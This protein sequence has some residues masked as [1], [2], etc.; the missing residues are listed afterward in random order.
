M[1]YTPQTCRTMFTSQQAGRML[2]WLN[3]VLVGWIIGI[4]VDADQT[5]GPAPLPV[6]F[7][8]ATA[9]TA[10]SWSWDFGDGGTS[11]EANPFHLFE[12]PGKRDVTIT[13]QTPEGP[14]VQHCP[15]LV[16][17]Y[18][19]S[20][21]AVDVTGLS[22]HPVKVDIAISNYLQ[23]LGIVL[24]IYYGGPLGLSYDSFTV[25][26]TRTESFE[27]AT[28]LNLDKINK[29]LTV[30]LSAGSGNELSPGSGPILSLYLRIPSW[31]QTGT[32]P[33]DVSGYLSYVPKLTCPAGD[34]L[35]E[36][37]EGTV[38]ATCCSGTVGNVNFDYLDQVDIGDLTKLIDYLFISYFPPYCMAEANCNGSADGVVDIGDL[39][40]LIDYLF[41]SQ[42]P[43]PD[44]L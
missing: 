13:I 12:T 6:Q 18:A 20:L 25:A 41:I 19:D 1:G 4:K 43:L 36:A 22:G 11:D 27:S 35:A 10:L 8:T 37:V 39:T 17:T 42:Q 29:R 34:Y 21:G 23:V 28:L 16:S 40:K 14:F 3:D 33:I 5:F 38:T 24:P 30:V 32:N 7:T 2:C 31:A 26:G 44:C 15:G 9:K